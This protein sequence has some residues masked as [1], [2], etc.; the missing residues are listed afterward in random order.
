ML[1][2]I[3]TKHG[4]IHVKT[5]STKDIQKQTTIN[6][7]N[8]DPKRESG[9]LTFPILKS[10]QQM[11][12]QEVPGTPMTSIIFK[13]STCAGP[14]W[15]KLLEAGWVGLRWSN[16]IFKHKDNGV[17]ICHAN[18]PPKVLR[19]EFCRSYIV[20]NRDRGNHSSDEEFLKT[21]PD[22]VIDQNTLVRPR[23]EF[24]DY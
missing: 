6:L 3:D 23:I 21:G 22:Q 13:G 17:G 5:R 11:D 16:L 10:M 2:D 8:V 18:H 1:P 15:T 12:V 19:R 14:T 7:N 20:T 24:T 9:F 4:Q